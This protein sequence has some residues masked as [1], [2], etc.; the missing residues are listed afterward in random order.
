MK[1]E[2]YVEYPGERAA[3]LMPYSENVRVEIDHGPTLPEHQ[4]ELV[5]HLR[6]SLADFYDGAKVWLKEEFDAYIDQLAQDEE[7]LG[8]LDE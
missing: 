2:F 3:G 7:R 5:E 8:E 6:Q 4:R 1:I